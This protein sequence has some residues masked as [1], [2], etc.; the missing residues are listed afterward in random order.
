MNESILDSTKAGLGI[1]PDDTSFDNELIMDI[2]SVLMIFDQLGI[3]KPNPTFQVTDNTQTWD[4]Y[5]LD[6][7]NLAAA[8]SLMVY[9]VKLM[10]DSSTMSSGLMQEINSKIQEL[11]WRLNVRAEIE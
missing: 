2:N 4:E 1:E 3:S 11:E 7:V 8:K 9:R 6:G 5:L 10:F